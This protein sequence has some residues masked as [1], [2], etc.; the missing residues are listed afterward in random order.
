MMR[1][2]D[3]WVKIHLYILCYKQSQISDIIMKNKSHL[4]K[5]MKDLNQ[6]SS[7]LA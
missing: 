1:I 3:F 4:K 5:E 7:I 6:F 2:F